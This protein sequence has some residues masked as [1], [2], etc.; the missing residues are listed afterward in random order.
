MVGAAPDAFEEELPE[1]G[2]ELVLAAAPMRAA[3]AAAWAASWLVK[4]D[5]SGT[6]MLPNAFP[7]WPPGCAVRK[8]SESGEGMTI[9]SAAAIR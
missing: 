1:V 5:G 7:T 3:S 2:V 4:P 8:T 9:P 6:W